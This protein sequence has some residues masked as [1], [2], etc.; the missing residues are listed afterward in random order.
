M[1]EEVAALRQLK[2]HFAAPPQGCA[3]FGLMR[4]HSAYFFF[5]YFWF[6]HATGGREI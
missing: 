6:S 4:S 1:V 2:F 3:T 5:G